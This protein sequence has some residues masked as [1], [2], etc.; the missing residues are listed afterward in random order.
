VA[1]SARYFII[2]KLKMKAMKYG[3]DKHWCCLFFEVKRGVKLLG[4]VQGFQV[5]LFIWWMFSIFTMWTGFNEFFPGTW[6]YAHCF[7]IAPAMVGMWYYYYFLTSRD[8]MSKNPLPRAHIMNIVS[9]VI[10]FLS[11]TIYGLAWS[12]ATRT[13]VT[14]ERRIAPLPIG[15]IQNY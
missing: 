15:G 8:P 7:A 13:D 14:P 1:K 12:A 4:I 10:Y 5:A 9:M 11:F 6:V 3:F 2:I